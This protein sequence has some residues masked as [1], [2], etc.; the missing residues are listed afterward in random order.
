MTM[1]SPVVAILWESWR[2][3]RGE[4]AWRLALGIIASLAVPVVFGVIASN[5]LE[6]PEAVSHLGAAIALFLIVIPN[7]VNWP[8]VAQLNGWRPGFP[9]HLLYTRPVRTA[10]LVGVPMAYLVV[11]PTAIFIISALLLRETSGYPV[12]LLRAAAWIAGLNVALVATHW[13]SRT[14]LVQMLGGMVPSAISGPV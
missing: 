10:V 12:P 7:L 5:F 13:S 1:Q 9:L 14:R 11:A 4:A 8:S 3:T 2:M 6:E